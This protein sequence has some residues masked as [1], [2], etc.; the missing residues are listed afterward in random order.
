[1]LC[2][3]CGLQMIHHPLKALV[4]LRDLLVCRLGAVILLRIPEDLLTRHRKR[5]TQALVLAVGIVSGAHLAPAVTAVIMAAGHNQCPPAEGG[6]YMGVQN[7]GG[8][9]AAFATAP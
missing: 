5:A 8:I 4:R 9:C 7:V 1:M 6:M 3:L 2:A